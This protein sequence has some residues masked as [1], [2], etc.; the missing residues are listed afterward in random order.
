M[1]RQSAILAVVIGL[2]IFVACDSPG[3]PSPPPPPPPPP[4]PQVSLTNIRIEGPAS[5]PPG[6]SAQFRLVA[7][8]RDGTN[9][10]VASQATWS[11]DNSPVL[12]FSA[13]GVANAKARGEVHIVARY[14]TRTA[15]AHIFVLE[16]GTFRVTGRV[17]ES[18]AGLPD[19]KVEVISG[20]GTG[21]SAIT[22]SSGT[23]SL[24]GLAGEV[25][26][27]AT[28]SG[29][30]KERRSLVVTGNTGANLELRASNTPADL[31]GDWRLTLTASPEC[32]STFPQ[33]ATTRTYVVTIGQTGTVLQFQIKSPFI[34]DGM[35]VSGRVIDRTV[36]LSLPFDDF[37]YS[38]YGVKYYAIVE[39][40]APGRLLAIA[41][42]GRGNRVG[43]AVDGTL[44]GEFAM[45]RN[46]SF[47]AVRNLDFSCQRNNHGFRLER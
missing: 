30:E 34:L 21:L 32:P 9:T 5:I 3:S 35:P 44:D 4:L 19:V 39:P 26:L 18:G 14:Q 24:Y 27:E 17:T 47:G 36:T 15:Q 2:S 13:G 25:E 37:Y 23:Y 8:F 43:D 28:L 31:R 45:Y 12:S 6:E 1:A 7:T 33:D 10:D 42:N 29:F 22:G 41:G 46:E 11:T 16:D 20:T 40:L 38:F